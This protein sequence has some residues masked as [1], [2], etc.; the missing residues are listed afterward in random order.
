MHR[1]VSIASG[2]LDSLPANGYLVML[3]RN[4][5]G[6]THA[7]SYG[8]IFVTT[9]LLPAAGTALAIALFKW[10]PSWQMM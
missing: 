1:V 6:E 9:V 3:I 8:P 2:S 7:R 4:I 5:C 10:F